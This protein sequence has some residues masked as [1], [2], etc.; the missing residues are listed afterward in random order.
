MT[1][2]VI[3]NLEM[4]GR[5]YELYL[6]LCPDLGCDETNFYLLSVPTCNEGNT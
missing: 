6:D 4:K 2:M 5:G 3:A 1:Y